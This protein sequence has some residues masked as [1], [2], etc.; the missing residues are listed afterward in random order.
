[1]YWAAC[2]LELCKLYDD[3]GPICTNFST[4]PKPSL[5]NRNS[6][7]WCRA[8]ICFQTY[9]FWLSTFKFLLESIFW[10]LSQSLPSIFQKR[11]PK[12]CSL[13]HFAFQNPLP[14]FFYSS[15][16]FASL[17]PTTFIAFL[18]I[19]SINYMAWLLGL[20]SKSWI[21]G[22]KNPSMVSLHDL[23]NLWTL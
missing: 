4:C 10:F 17:P 12:N 8:L 9:D 11:S 6:H 7:V 20:L 19:A 5:L 14:V 1:M 23:I 13:H 16:N 15:L 21:K 22:S 2:N 18:S 3:V